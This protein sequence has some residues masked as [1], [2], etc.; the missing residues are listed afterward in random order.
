MPHAHS[1]KCTEKQKPISTQ[2]SAFFLYSPCG[3]DC[4]L[5]THGQ[6]AV[7]KESCC[8]LGRVFKGTAKNS[9]FTDSITDLCPGQKV[10]KGWLGNSASQ[11]YEKLNRPNFPRRSPALKKF[12]YC[13]V[14]ITLLLSRDVGQL[15]R[16]CLCYCFLSKGLCPRE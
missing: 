6:H 5:T 12:S 16:I 7:N 13:L 2:Q 8:S 11:H 10:R 14:F 1:I 3:Y 15:Q 4:Q 9:G